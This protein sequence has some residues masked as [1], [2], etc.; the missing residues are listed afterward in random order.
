M[1]SVVNCYNAVSMYIRSIVASCHKV[2]GTCV[3]ACMCDV[4]MVETRRLS[5]ADTKYCQLSRSL[6]ST[7]IELLAYDA[8][9]MYGRTVSATLSSLHEIWLD[10]WILN[11]K[12]I[13][14]RDD[15]RH[16][17]CRAQPRKDTFHR[18]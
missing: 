12:D 18:P 8:L 10:I 7:E 17:I 6:T 11:R 5:T 16:T 14:A 9:C 15:P 4:N 13:V 1:Q 3:G 2:E